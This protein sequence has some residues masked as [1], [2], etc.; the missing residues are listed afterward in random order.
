MHSHTICLGSAAIFPAGPAAESG[1]CGRAARQS[2]GAEADRGRIQGA[3]TACG[4]VRRGA[5]IGMAAG[6]LAILIVPLAAKGQTLSLVQTIV[7]G[8]NML[9]SVMARSMMSQQLGRHTLEDAAIPSGTAEA[10]RSS[11][12]SS[13]S[14]L[15]F[16]PSPETTQQV[17]AQLVAN[18]A[19]RDGAAAAQL[20]K[21]LAS[22]TLRQRLAELLGKFGYSP[23]NL[24]DVMTAYLILSW[25]TVRNGDATRYPQGIAVVHRRL[26]DALAANPKVAALSD[27]QKQG[28]AETL[29]DLAMLDTI[30]RKQLLKSGDTAR[31]RQLEQ[32]TRQATLKLGVD[33][34]ALQLTDRGF[35]RQ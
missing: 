18:V 15:L 21:L 12:P 19:Q 27:S 23:D 31:L 11:V 28:F 14:V 24:A 20:D 8:G 4:N 5:L 30:V 35:V 16:R 29:A 25:E 6:I 26:R 3:I 7:N 1:R 10:H 34:G 33:V 22:G 9:N 17:N 32:R 2:S 13:P